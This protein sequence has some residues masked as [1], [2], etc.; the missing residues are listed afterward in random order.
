MTDPQAPDSTPDG[1]STP[2]P[3]DRQYDRTGFYPAEGKQFRVWAILAWNIGIIVAMAIAAAII[4]YI[5][6]HE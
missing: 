2:V 4:N 6:L 3:P 1:T 5:V